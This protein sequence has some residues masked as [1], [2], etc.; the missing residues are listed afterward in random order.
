MSLEFIAANRDSFDHNPEV[1][2]QLSFYNIIFFTEGEGK[3]FI[4]F[5]WFPVQK[6]TLVYLTKDQINAFDFSGN[7]NGFCILFTEDY[8]AKCFANLPKDFVYRLFNPQLF[9]PIL[10]IPKHAEFAKYFNLIKTEFSKKT[11]FNQA[12]IIQSLFVILISKAEQYK[13]EQ[14]FHIKDDS[15]ILLFQKFMILLENQFSKSRNADYYAK[16][17]A[18]S[19]KHL[20][21]ICKALVNKTAKQVIN[22]F[23]ILQAKRKLINST[24]KST[25]LGYKLGFEDPTNFT[26]YFKK[27]TGLTPKQ[28][29]N[30]ILK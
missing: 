29:K 1:P 26:K 6:N 22:D 5:N 11:A 25:T 8:F 27:N 13:Q 24:I 16:E 9:S 7:L 19:Y 10:H 20:N 23:V 14:T 18:I 12:T 4:D 28:F 21:T 2:H 17:I 15:K 3:H 30:S